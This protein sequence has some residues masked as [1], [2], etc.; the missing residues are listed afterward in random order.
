MKNI[1]DNVTK[2][3]CGIGNVRNEGSLL[4]AQEQEILNPNEKKR[5]I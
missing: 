1:K 2:I 4:M 5:Y 3:I